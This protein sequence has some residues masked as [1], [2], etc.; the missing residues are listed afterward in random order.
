[1]SLKE[2]PLKSLSV[3]LLCAAFAVSADA[4][5]TA[6]QISEFRI[7]IKQGCTARGLQRGDKNAASFCNCMDK[8][9]RENLSNGDF[10]EMARLSAAGKGPGDM[11]IMKA[12]L[13]K[14]EACKSADGA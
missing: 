6:S 4:A 1:M 3:L 2:S 12:Q 5:M 9:L 7:S 10:E 8:V 14:L 13:P 11:P